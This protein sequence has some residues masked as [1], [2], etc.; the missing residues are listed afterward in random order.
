ML[1]VSAPAEASVD[2][3]PV[4]SAE[5]TIAV[6]TIETIFEGTGPVPSALNHVFAYL[7]VDDHELVAPLAVLRDHENV[8]VGLLEW[9]YQNPSLEGSP[10]N[11]ALV[12]VAGRLRSAA[13]V[14][15]LVSVLASP[16]PEPPPADDPDDHHGSPFEDELVL[17]FMTVSALHSLA[18]DGVDDARVAL[19]QI[20]A[21]GAHYGGVRE[22]AVVWLRALGETDAELAL[23]AGADAHLLDVYTHPT[24]E[25]LDAE[26]EIA[27]L[28]DA[29]IA[30]DAI[31]APPPIMEEAP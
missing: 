12:Y 10:S 13:A 22:M 26:W 29:A 27:D 3:E 25:D 31:P 20:L 2:D 14:P 23:W 15:F 17:R 5:P 6:A 24:E 18:K 30:T 28:L 19:R 4:A 11:D 8:T 21:N 1:L 7:A 9:R 16:M